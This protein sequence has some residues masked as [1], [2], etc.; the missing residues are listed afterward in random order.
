MIINPFK[1]NPAVAEERF[2]GSRHRLPDPRRGNGASSSVPPS[3]RA[4]ARR[5]I[6][7][8]ERSGRLARLS[9][10]RVRRCIG[11]FSIPGDRVECRRRRPYRCK[12][13]GPPAGRLPIR[14]HVA[15]GE[16]T[17]GAARIVP[18][19][20]WSPGRCC[21]SKIGTPVS[22]QGFHAHP[23][24]TPHALHH[25]VVSATAKGKVGPPY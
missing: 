18:I 14:P 6:P 10:S 4:P 20:A 11:R 24:I 8:T 9:L 13:T 22:P 21:E 19:G 15:G 12:T 5:A 2:S 1:T 23:A 17:I 25:M 7:R 3:C 16:N